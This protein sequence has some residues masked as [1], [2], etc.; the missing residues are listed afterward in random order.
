[1]GEY[2]HRANSFHC[3]A[4]DFE[5][6]NNYCQAIDKGENLCY[7]YL[8]DWKEIMEDYQPEIAKMVKK[9]KGN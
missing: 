3:Y 7:S 6:L 2:T 5:L 1:M 9:L 8:D 4:K